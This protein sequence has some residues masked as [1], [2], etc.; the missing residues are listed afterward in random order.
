MSPRLEQWKREAEVGRNWP[1]PE[2]LLSR[3]IL[4]LIRVLAA[5][6][7][8]SEYRTGDTFRECSEARA[9]LEAT[10]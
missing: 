7:A 5:E 10:E 3:R 2:G 9:A 8:D 4:V 6:E 1:G